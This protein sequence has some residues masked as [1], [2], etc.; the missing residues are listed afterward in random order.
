MHR[1][2]QSEADMQKR[3]FS[4]NRKQGLLQQASIRLSPNFDKRPES[5]DISLIVIHNISLPPGEYGGSCI[6]DLFCNELNTN[7]HPYY[8]Q[9][10]G[11]KV[12][13]HILINR[14]GEVKQYVPFHMRAWHAGASSYKGR[15]NCNDFS[16]GIEL[17]GTDID[18]YTEDQYEVLADIISQLIQTYP[19]LS[20][21]AI[22]GHC[23][24]APERKTDPGSA[25]DWKKLKAGMVS[26]NTYCLHK[27]CNNRYDSF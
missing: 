25:F 8:K 11:L 14:A 21:T 24:I 19:S 5:N 12:S 9:L 20:S 23:H 7:A 27:K 26:R 13:S 10:K 18:P 16:I 3:Q 15:E 17:E 22:T 4:I 1:Y 6:D 2:N